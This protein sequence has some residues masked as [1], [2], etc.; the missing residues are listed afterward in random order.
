MEEYNAGE[1]ELHWRDKVIGE[2]DRGMEMGIVMLEP[3]ESSAP[4]GGL[5][6]IIRMAGAE[7]LE[8]ERQNAIR[9]REAYHF[10]KEMIRER[11]LPIKLTDVMYCFDGSKITFSF[12]AEERVD[13][14]ELVKDLIQKYHTRVELRQ[15]GVRDETG[16]IGGIGICGRDVCCSLFLKEF[17]PVTVK[18]AKDQAIAFNPQK[19]SGYCGRLKCCLAFEYDFYAGLKKKAPS[20]PD[21]PDVIEE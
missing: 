5:K 13:F 9:E 8:R 19:A 17:E 2:T 1:L 14:R 10:C 21:M 20:V 7:D 12:T 6:K 11:G 16:K 3:C 4:P 15:I 18:M